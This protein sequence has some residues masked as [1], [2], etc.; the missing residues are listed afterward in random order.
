MFN[1]ARRPRAARR[2]ARFAFLFADMFASRST[3]RCV[4]SELRRTAQASLAVSPIRKRDRNYIN[5]LLTRKE[6]E[7]IHKKYATRLWK[8][9]ASARAAHVTSR[10]ATG[11]RAST[12]ASLPAPRNA[13]RFISF[14]RLLLDYVL[15]VL[16]DFL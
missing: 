3:E 11:A 1:E 4:S 8:A 2:R 14:S 10:R 9:S 12:P 13:A 7:S 5:N 15:R 6:C 16:T